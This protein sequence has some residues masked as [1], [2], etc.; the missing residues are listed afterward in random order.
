MQTLLF[1]GGQEAVNTDPTIPPTG[2]HACPLNSQVVAGHAEFATRQR[3]LSW[4]LSPRFV[5]SKSCK[6]TLL[7]KIVR[8]G[9]FLLRTLKNRGP[10]LWSF[11][12]GFRLQTLSRTRNT[13][14]LQKKAF[15]NLLTFESSK[16]KP[17]KA[18]S[19]TSLDS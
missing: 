7:G 1:M 17:A 5:F 8:T 19:M 6:Y 2:R 10:R 9:G 4:S 3:S 15:N 11:H 18:H 14:T 16:V 12:L 13:A